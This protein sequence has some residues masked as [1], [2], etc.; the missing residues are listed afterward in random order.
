MKES[1]MTEKT[2]VAPKASREHRRKCLKNGS[3]LLNGG[4]SEE[5]EERGE[6]ATGGLPAGGPA[7]AW[8]LV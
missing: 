4:S 2:H 8:L 7:G 3:W 6:K 5:E 1:S